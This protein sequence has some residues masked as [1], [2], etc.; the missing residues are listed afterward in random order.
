MFIAPEGKRI[1]AV[2]GAVNG[3]RLKTIATALS[4]LVR[5][6]IAIQIGI[7]AGTINIEDNC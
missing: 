6:T 1:M 4:G 5:I 2:T 7:K 3:N